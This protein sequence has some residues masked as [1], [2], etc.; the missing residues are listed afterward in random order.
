[1]DNNN[2]VAIVRDKVQRYLIDLLGNIEIDRDGDFHF[3]NGTTHVFVRVAPFADASTVVSVWAIT[4]AD[5]TPTA[6]L[7]KFLATEN[8][9]RFGSLVCDEQDGKALIRFAHNLLG[10]FLDPDE[11]KMTVAMVARTADEIDDKI[12]EKFGGRTF[13]GE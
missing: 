1:M 7:Y 3:R 6:D 5:L 12:K 13:H 10:D 4:N 11:L 2:Q 8:H 9:Y